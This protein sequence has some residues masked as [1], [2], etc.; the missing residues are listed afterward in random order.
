MPTGRLG[1]AHRLLT[2]AMTALEAAAGPAADADELLSVL[3]LCEETTRRL[4][5]TAVATIATL[6][7]QGTFA[8]RGYRSPELALADLLNWERAEARRRTVAAGHVRPRT[9]LDGTILP[10]ALPATAE[11]FADGRIGLGHVHVIAAVLGSH[12]ARRIDPERLTQAEARIAEH[13][14]VYNPAELRTWATR[15]IEALDDDDPEPDDAPPPQL[16][17]LTVVGHRSGAGGRIT[18][19][20]DDAAL[21]D[22]IATAADALSAPRDGLDERRPEE[23]RAEALAEICA[24]ALDRGTVPD[25]GGRRPVIS[26]LIGLDDLQRRARAAV[27]DFGGTTT[28]ESLRMLA[29]DAGIVPIVMNGAGQPLDVGRTRRTVP[30]GLRRAV[31]A[32]DHGCAHPGCDRPPSWCEVHHIVPWETGGATA[33][34]NSVMLCRVHHRLMHHSEWIIRIRHGLPEFVPPRWIDPM[35]RPRS[36]PRP[37]GAA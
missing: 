35:Q 23:R 9:A 25:T 13:A 11:R 16:N 33:L 10:A 17:T 21:F 22:A 34:D 5:R 30:D 24:H 31:T 6:D 3:A 36:R 15:L 4:D 7:R 19:R 8:E 20:Y 37:A 27:L 29:C 26:V 12:A 1:T 2:E 14:T 18:G 32:R 28:P